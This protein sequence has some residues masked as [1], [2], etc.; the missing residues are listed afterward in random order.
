LQAVDLNSLVCEVSE[1]YRVNDQQIDVSLTL[2]ELPAVYLDSGRIRQLVVNLLKNAFEALE[3]DTEH[4]QVSI[5]TEYVLAKQDKPEICLAISDTGSGIPE[6]VLP[7][8][9]D[10]Y[11]SSKQK[12]SGLGLSIVKK[13]VEEHSARVIAKNNEQYGATVS[14]YFPVEIG[15]ESKKG[16]SLEVKH[17]T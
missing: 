1:L 5:T 8:L 14:I 2:D 10:P 11:V 16:K 3:G 9:F 17:V 13:I 7:Q 15:M 4:R 6:D 12:G